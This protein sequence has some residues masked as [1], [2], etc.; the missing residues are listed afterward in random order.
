MEQNREYKDR[1]FRLLFGRED[2]K[3]NILSLY[4][5]LQGTNYTDPDD[6]ELTTIEDAIYIGMKNDVSFIIDNRMPLWE[7]QSTYNPNMPVRG[8][9]YYGKL[10]DAYLKKNGRKQYS[11]MLVKIPTPQYIVFYNGG[12]EWPAVERMK[13]SDAF[14]DRSFDP[15]C[16]WTATVY[17]LNSDANRALLDS[18]KPLA[19]Y[20][21]LVRRISS[22]L[23]KGMEK[24]EAFRAVDEAVRS[25]IRDGIL[26]DFLT[27][28]RAEVIDLWITEF[29]EKEFA[30]TMYEEGKQAGIE[31]GIEKGIEKGIEHMLRAGKTPEAIHD[32]CDI[33]LDL[34]MKV[35]SS[36]DDQ[37]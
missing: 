25:C 37:N 4:N 3:D 19:D 34:I 10:Y 16:E 21:E 20:T 17:N 22:K 28:Q 12:R 5:A 13:L 9:I 30:E 11:T 32:F 7:Q 6:I 33:P 14:A 35:K 31:E 15:G 27:K 18:C 8:L 26:A 1:L 29:D 36:F 2:N 24:D 23:Q